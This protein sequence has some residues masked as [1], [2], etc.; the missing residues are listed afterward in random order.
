MPVLKVKTPCKALALSE[1]SEYLTLMIMLITSID[2]DDDRSDF[3]AQQYI[4]TK[5]PVYNL[6]I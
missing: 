4:F 2:A 3:Q 6:S 1:H 5:V